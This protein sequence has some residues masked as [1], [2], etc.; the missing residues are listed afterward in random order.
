MKNCF[1]NVKKKKKEKD[2]KLMSGVSTSNVLCNNRQGMTFKHGR[3]FKRTEKMF[4]F[5]N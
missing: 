5:G 1:K 4:F 2:V 3:Q